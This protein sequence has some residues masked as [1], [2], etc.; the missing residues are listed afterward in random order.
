[1]ATK[2]AKHSIEVVTHSPIKDDRKKNWG[3]AR[4]AP[5]MKVIDGQ[6]GFQPPLELE[7]NPPDMAMVRQAAQ[8]LGHKTNTTALEW[9]KIFP[10]RKWWAFA[11]QATKYLAKGPNYVYFLKALITAGRAGEK[12]QQ[13]QG[14]LKSVLGKA[15]EVVKQEQPAAPVCSCASV[16]E[17]C[18]PQFRVYQK[19]LAAWN[20]RRWAIQG[21]ST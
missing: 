5:T 4:L 2:K 17:K 6:G 12:F 7:G 15:A 20:N 13:F 14:L 10:A 9:W 19:E 16:C 8:L 18:E 21:G 11:L 1:M 3:A